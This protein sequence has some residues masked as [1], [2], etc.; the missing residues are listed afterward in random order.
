MKVERGEKVIS[1]NG[2]IGDVVEDFEGVKWVITE[3]IDIAGII[4][5]NYRGDSLDNSN[6]RNHYLMDRY[7]VANYGRLSTKLVLV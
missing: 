2:E 5:K 6:H 7:L 4:E 3:V 1:V